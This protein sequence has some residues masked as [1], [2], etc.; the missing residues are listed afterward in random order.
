MTVKEALLRELKDLSTNDYQV[1]LRLIQAWKRSQT[2]STS[3]VE[4]L[5]DFEY[6]GYD[7]EKSVHKYKMFIKEE[8][9]NRINTLHGGI[10]AT[11]VDTVMGISLLREL[12]S[13]IK[14]V[15]L[16]LNMKYLSPGIKGCTIAE[17]EIVKTGKTILTVDAKVYDE[18]KKLLATASGTFF[19]IE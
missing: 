4:Q 14:V 7:S 17:I 10:T 11:F 13:D 2:G 3:F 15:T 6:I 9:R 8:L 19:R 12:G 1:L 5:M 18:E 16:D